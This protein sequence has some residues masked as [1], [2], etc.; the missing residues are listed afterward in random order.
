MVVLQ[1]VDSLL[2]WLLGS[3]VSGLRPYINKE[4]ERRWGSPY[5][6]DMG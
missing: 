6:P 3:Q 1:G 4:L 5:Y 2:A